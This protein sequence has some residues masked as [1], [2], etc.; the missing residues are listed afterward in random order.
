MGRAAAARPL[1]MGEEMIT[2]FLPGA[3]STA[4]QLELEEVAAAKLSAI[5]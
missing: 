5:E 3:M 4:R 1:R 2:G